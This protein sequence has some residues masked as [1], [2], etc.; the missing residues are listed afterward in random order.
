MTHDLEQKLRRA[1][2]PVDP[3]PEFTARL[4]TG[5]ATARDSASAVRRPRWRPM[6]LAASVV[7][8]LGLGVL[9]YQQQ[10]RERAHAQLLEALSITSRS[11]DLAYRAVRWHGNDAAEHGG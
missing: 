10:Q 8:T 3:S 9:A 11:L 2:R 6:A 7:L 1:L 5:L 4:L